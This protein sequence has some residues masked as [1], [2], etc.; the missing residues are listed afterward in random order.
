M[1]IT[2]SRSPLVDMR[3]VPPGLLGIGKLAREGGGHSL[4]NRGDAGIV[5]W[6]ASMS[7]KAVAAMACSVSSARQ[8]SSVLSGR[9]ASA[10]SSPM[11]SS[12]AASAG[13]PCGK[14]PKVP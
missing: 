10:S 9:A 14:S 5:A 3:P 13:S 1:R 2:M 4:R 7:R 12:K 8:S 6:P 11:Y